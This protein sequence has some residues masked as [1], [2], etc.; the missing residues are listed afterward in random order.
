[1]ADMSLDIEK[2]SENGGYISRLVF[3]NDKEIEIN[4]NDIVIF[5]GPNNAGKSQALRD[6]YELCQSKKPTIVVKDLDIIK[7]NGNLEELL[8]KISVTTNQGNYKNYDGFRYNISSL[9]MPGYKDDK[10]YGS[11]RPVFVAHLD[12]QNRLGICEPAPAIARKAAKGHPIHYVAF[13]RKYRE[14]LS[15]NFKKAFGKEIIP[16]IQNVINI[17][18][19]IGEAIK[20]TGD[21]DDEQTRQEDFADI[22]ATYEQVQDQGDGIKSFTGILLYLMIDH[23]CTFLIDEPESFLHPPQAK[24]MGHIIGETLREYQQAFIS[25]HSED[26]I[27]GLLDVCPKR[28]KI[29]RVTREE[30]INSFSVLDNKRF[31]EIWTDPLLKYSNIMTSL[32]HK[33]VVLCESDADCKMYSIIERHLKE[34]KGKYSETLFIHC[35]GKHRMARIA[36]ALRSLDI[37]IKL[38][39]DIDV[40]NDETV[41]KGIVEAFGIEWQSIS[42]SY[43]IIVSNL[44]SRKEVINRDDFQEE[45]SRI[46]NNSAEKELSKQEISDLNSALQVESKWEPLKKNGIAA[47]PSGDATI[48]FDNLN[49]TLKEAGIY[50]VTV[51]ELECFIKQVGGHGPDWTN[52]VLEKYANLNDAVYDEIK[53][54]I[55]TVCDLD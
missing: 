22:L 33:E 50:I 2:I 29:I 37:Q 27:K 30:N 4:E 49:Q 1:M 34:Q 43:K 25:T 8:D 45:V 12:T 10:Y 19:C 26:I 46:L 13:D 51:G 17:P 9:S 18:L 35:N 11:T 52:N 42:S 6:I 44:H 54:F 47:L 53:K 38:I 40:L 32:F 55:K 5:V 16:Y 39:P 36:K 15:S 23:Y 7:R 48:A 28:V 3:N 31:N 41:F 20:L 24:T 21:Y 14:W